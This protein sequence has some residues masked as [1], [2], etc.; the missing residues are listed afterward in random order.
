[1]LIILLRGVPCTIS[2]RPRSRIVTTI[3]DIYSGIMLYIMCTIVWVY[4]IYKYEQKLV[5][6]IFSLMVLTAWYNN[7]Y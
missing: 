3:N 6:C 5:V 7:D 2:I 4:P 1:M